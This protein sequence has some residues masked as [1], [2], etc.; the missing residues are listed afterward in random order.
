MKKNIDKYQVGNFIYK[1]RT[2]KNLTQ[3][4][5][6]LLLGVTN[7]AVSKW[8]TGE[9][10]PEVSML[11]KLAGVFEV[12]VDEILNA[13]KCD[14]VSGMNFLKSQLEEIRETKIKKL[15][16]YL[17]LVILLPLLTFG[18]SLLL[19]FTYIKSIGISLEPSYNNLLLIISGSIALFV[20]IV[21]NLNV[22]YQNFIFKLP[23][24]VQVIFATFLPLTLILAVIASII[25]FPIVYV[26]ILREVVD[27]LKTKSM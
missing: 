20:F 14:V 23:K 15:K 9:N 24:T 7:K 19:M 22:Y 25:A 16:L 5:L 27:E 4:E 26:Y 3:K 21:I 8:E 12:T 11:Y 17:I 18:F 1:C 10:R 2:N 6:A 13:E